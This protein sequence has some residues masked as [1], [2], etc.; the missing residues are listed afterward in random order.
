MNQ[1]LSFRYM[2]LSI[3]CLG[4]SLL[5]G[6]DACQTIIRTA[7][8]NLPSR[9]VLVT[10]HGDQTGFVESRVS[11]DG[12]N[13]SGPNYPRTPSGAKSPA[14]PQVSAGIGTNTQEY[15]LVWFDP[16]GRLHSQSS[17]DGLAWGGDKTY[18]TYQPTID[19]R[20]AVVYNYTDQSWWTAFREGNEIVIRQLL[21]NGSGAANRV[22]VPNIERSVA[23]SWTTDGFIL[24]YR[25]SAPGDLYM[26]NSPDGMS[27]DPLPGLV[28]QDINGSPIRSKGSPY[29]SYS[30]G[31]LR[32]G[33]N[34]NFTP[35]QGFDSG[36][37]VLYRQTTSGSW[38]LEQEL[39]RILFNSRGVAVAGP[40]DNLVIAAANADHTAMWWKF[41]ERDAIPTATELEPYL[42]HGPAGQADLYTVEIS[43]G[44]Y[45]RVPEPSNWNYGDEEDVSLE[46]N[47]YT[48]DGRLIDRMEPM[49]FEDLIKGTT[50]VWGQKEPYYQTPRF[51]TLLQPQEYIEIAITGDEGRVTANLTLTEFQQPPS[52]IL[53]G[54]LPQDDAA[55]LLKRNSLS[56]SRVE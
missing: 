31:T 33:T 53:V 46:I 40:S 6:C 14:H 26:L 39:E 54:S 3:L 30:L 51:Q 45:K 50:H 44:D 37:I 34:D 2:R 43:L 27:W 24:I 9:F 41:R 56:M 15:L 22:S 21:P 8:E 19:S 16:S 47:H 32:L 23:M 28:V 13:W 20:P 42:S 35:T 38:E 36:K 48:E 5:M 18:G 25:S 11:T 49:M 52:E 17:N 1:F 12:A 4:I 29:L 55:Y 10:T 7:Q